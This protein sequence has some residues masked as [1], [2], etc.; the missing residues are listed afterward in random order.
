MGRNERAG[1]GRLMAIGSAACLLLA[2]TV[3]RAEED[4]LGKPA[5]EDPRAVPPVVEPEPPMKKP[6]VIRPALPIAAANWT[7]NVREKANFEEK[8]WGTASE[9]ASDR[10]LQVTLQPEQKTFAGNGPLAFRV[11]LTNT[12]EKP[13]VLASGTGLGES[14]RLVF[15]NQKTAAQWAISAKDDDAKPLTIAAGE[16][17]SRT[18]IV[19]GGRL[20]LP[21]PV[22]RPIP[23]PLPAQPA[24]QPRRIRA[25][26]PNGKQL[27]R[28]PAIVIGM[29]TVPV[30]QGPVRARLMLDFAKSDEKG[31]W[32]GKLAS[33]TVEFVVGPPGQPVVPGVPTTKEQA[34]Q[35]ALPVAERAL[36]ANDT[37]VA[38]VRPAHVGTWIEDAEKTAKVDETDSGWR[39]TWTHTPKE[40]GFGYNVTIEVNKGGGATVREVFTSYSPR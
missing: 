2:V 9:P 5:V 26:L 10:G 31:A 14:P 40:K 11:T 25:L 18:L 22:P 3:G 8:E 13:L 23:R 1:L 24:I 17:V 29:A 27:I 15:S 33:S 20:I 21:Q 28:R 38:G 36:T 6:P 32:S 19:N 30:G 39:V 16:S 4:P 35:T 7:L 34:I 12:T 37:P